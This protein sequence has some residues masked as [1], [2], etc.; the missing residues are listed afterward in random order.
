MRGSFRRT[1]N[2]T[3]PYKLLAAALVIAF[4]FVTMLLRHSSQPARSPRPRDRGPAIQLQKWENDTGGPDTPKVTR[5]KDAMVHTFRN[6]R[7]AAWGHDDVL[8]VSGGYGD[9]RNGWGAFIVD[10]ASTLALMGL[11]HELKLAIEHIVRV[12]FTITEDLVDPFETTIRYLGGLLSLVD[13]IDSQVVPPSVVSPGDRDKILAQAVALANKL[14]PAYDS[15]TGL[16]WPRVDFALNQGVPDPPEVYLKDP[17]KPRYEHPVINAARAGSSILENRALSRLSGREIY[18]QNATK[19]WAPLVWNRYLEEYPGLVDTP[20]DIVTGDAVSHQHHWDA[21]HDSYYEYLLKAAVLAPGD[22]YSDRYKSRWLAAARSFHKQL[23]SRSTPTETHKTQHLFMGKYHTGN[24]LNVQSHLACW[25]PGSFLLGGAYLQ[26]KTM[27]NLGRALLEGCHHTYQSTTTGIGPE[28]FSWIP[29][30]NFPEIIYEPRA[31]RSKA[32]LAAHGFWAADPRFLLRPEYVEAVFYGWRITGEQ[33]YR[34][35]A[36][37][38]FEAMEK[39]CRTEHGYAAIAD[40]F[41]EE[42]RVVQLDEQESF[43][44]A[45]T[46]KYLWLTFADVRVGSLDDWVYTTEGHPL[47][48]DV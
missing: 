24:L 26:N 22:R 4:Y 2:P 48:R 32:E 46:L 37:E 44:S 28:S 14:G 10:S 45:E 33:R 38:A 43:W 36:W 35:W 5:V 8:P 42:G 17:S 18:Y 15:P 29:Y 21:G 3:T 12:D 23:T 40:V 16:A 9:S 11:W 7:A 34:D 19:S 13:L 25:A 1:S 41:A 30:T 27:L 39:H 47:R 20:I 31:D 6:Y